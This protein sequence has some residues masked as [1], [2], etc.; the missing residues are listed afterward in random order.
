MSV[1]ELLT[2]WET[3]N[4]ALGLSSPVRDDA[5]Y[6]ELLAF[7]DEVFEKF[8]HDDR[9]PIFTLVGLVAE[10]IREYEDQAHPWPDESTPASRLAFLIDSHQ[11]NQKDLPE[12]GPQSVVSEILS[13]K[14]QINLRQASALARRFGVPM[15]VFAG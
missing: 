13:G 10:R 12:I 1:T 15:E 8:G 7:V 14:R 9:H 5:H 6:A 3:I 11:L 4:T 2:S